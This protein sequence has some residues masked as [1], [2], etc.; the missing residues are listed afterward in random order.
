METTFLSEVSLPAAVSKTNERR[1]E[2]KANAMESGI[3]AG[4][5]LALCYTLLPLLG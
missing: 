5:G 1:R 3:I 4:P 2:V